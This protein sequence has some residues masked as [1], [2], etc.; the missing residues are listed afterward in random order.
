MDAWNGI[1][2]LLIVAWLAV[3]AVGLVL[4]LAE[5]WPGIAS[6][7]G[8]VGR[9][10]GDLSISRERFSLHVPL[11][12]SLVLSILLSLLFYVLSWLFRR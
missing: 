7:F 3:A 1:G 6:L 11:A 2:R 10:P 5:R 9:L 12:T 8:W 4:T